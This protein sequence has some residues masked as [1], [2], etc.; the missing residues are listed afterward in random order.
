[1]LSKWRKHCITYQYSTN[2]M[3]LIG[4]LSFTLLISGCSIFK[5]DT[6]K[7]E[8]LTEKLNPSK[9]R[10]SETIS[11]SEL[12]EEVFIG[13]AMSGGGSRAANFSA[14]VLLELERLG[15]LQHTAAISSVSGGSLTAA[16]YGLYGH[17]PEYWNE[18]LIRKHLRSNFELDWL[19]RWFL[20]W[21]LGRYWTSNFSR[22]DIMEQVLDSELYGD[23]QFKDMPPKLPK[24][25][26]NATSFTTGRRFV[27]SDEEF[28]S[29]LNSR[30]DTYPLANAVM[31]SAMRFCRLWV[32]SCA[33]CSSMRFFGGPLMARMLT[34]PPDRSVTHALLSFIEGLRIINTQGG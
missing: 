2:F 28:A 31:A 12:P 20:P 17:N 16:Y 34:Y 25:L 32:R 1:M 13:V 9:S 33:C 10:A 29:S 23:Q 19:G 21:N 26:I 11:K 24:I 27:F 15:I 8:L 5:I 30:L 22:S 14:A 4:L 7:N 3:I 18:Q 6:M